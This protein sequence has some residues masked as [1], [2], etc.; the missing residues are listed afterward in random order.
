MMDGIYRTNGMLAV[1]LT[2]GQ[3][4]RMGKD[5]AMLPAF[6]KP[7][8]QSLLDRFRAAGFDTAVSIAA[9]GRFPLQAGTELPDTFP[10]QG[11]MNG[12][13]AAFSMT[14]AE[15]ILLT[16]TDLPNGDPALARRLGMLRGENDVCV[17]RRADG[18]AETLF[19]V[20][21][22]A[23]FDRADECLRSGRRS[24]LAVLD[25]MR[26]RYVEEAELPEWD[27]RRV[28]RNVNTPE[29]YETFRAEDEPN[30]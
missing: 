4:S 15:S 18:T 28:L 12:I 17:I 16:A 9:A 13:Y 3:S 29:E 14:D 19:G 8:A 1:V 25:V 11:P 30:A 7:M 5:K 20:Y 27:L 22:R 6:G 26:V 24:L 23:C 2:G 10:G 21:T